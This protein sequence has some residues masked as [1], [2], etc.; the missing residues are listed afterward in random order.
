VT[1]FDG[2]SLFG[3]LCRY[4]R[5][6]YLH[7]YFQKLLTFTQAGFDLTTHNST[8]RDDTNRPRRQGNVGSFLIIT[9]V[10]QTL[11]VLFPSYKL[12][13]KFDK[14]WVGL[15]TFWAIFFTKLIRSPCSQHARSSKFDHLS[16][17]STFHFTF[18][19]SHFI[20]HISF[21]ISLDFRDKRS[22]FLN[23]AGVNI[24][25]TLIGDF[26]QFLAEKLVIFLL[27]QFHNPFC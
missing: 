4:Y 21:H 10:P 14:N 18:H 9:E 3:W 19:I 26:Q 22:F 16:R 5:Q 8:S 17:W 27:N 25:L 24:T 12:C 23:L 15:P 2:F 6:F 20:F 11:G 7:I 1:R 13:T